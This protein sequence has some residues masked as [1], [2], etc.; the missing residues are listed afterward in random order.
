[1]DK[2]ILDNKDDNSTANDEDSEE[3]EGAEVD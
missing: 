1:M 2:S 3:F